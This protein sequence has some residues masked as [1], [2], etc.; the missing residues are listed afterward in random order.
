MNTHCTFVLSTSGHIQSILRPP[1]IA[2]TTYYTNEDMSQDAESW[3]QSA[4]K[5][6]GSW[7]EHWSAWLTDRAGDK[8]TAPTRLGSDQ[9]PPLCP[10]PGLYVNE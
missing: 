2:N 8:R 9:H 7:W 3:L 5:N 1:S 4:Q 10:A 6:K